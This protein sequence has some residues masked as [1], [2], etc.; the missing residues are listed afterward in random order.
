MKERWL[1]AAIVLLPT[2]QF[3]L[4]HWVEAAPLARLL[5][6]G[7]ALAPDQL[8]RL[9]RAYRL[10]GLLMKGWQAFLLLEGVA[11]LTGN[12][13]AK[14]LRRIEDQIEEMETEIAALRAE[15][16]DL[17]KRVAAA[18]SQTAEGVPAPQG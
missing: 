8:A 3:I 4:I 16:D 10:R 9:S 1:D 17:R 14:R 7:R 6:L 18:Q 2:L 15:A 11:R 5:R 13:P 12:T